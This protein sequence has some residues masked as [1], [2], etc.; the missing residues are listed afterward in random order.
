ML[1]WFYRYGDVAESAEGGTLLRCYMGQPVSWVRI[2]PS[3]NL[4]PPIGGF[5]IGYVGFKVVFFIV[6]Q[7]CQ[8]YILLCC[9][10]EIYVN[11]CYN[12]NI[13]C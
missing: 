3:P 9:K 8:T 10:I 7:V 12:E 1:L 6:E 4:N 2:P 13:I 5:F 11:V